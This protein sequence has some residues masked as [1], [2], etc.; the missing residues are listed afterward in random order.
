M[1]TIMEI[2]ENNK[3][4]S[5]YFFNK[6]TMKFFNS[7]IESKLYAD[8]TFITSERENLQAPRTYTIRIALDNGRE[9][10]TIGKFQQFE[11]LISARE[12]RK[13]EQYKNNLKKH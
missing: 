4:N 11:S 8:N 9:I 6:Q 7:K 12:Y 13:T 5:R 1:S 3:Q 10:G 2:K